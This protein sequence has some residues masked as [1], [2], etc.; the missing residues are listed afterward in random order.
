MESRTLVAV[1]QLMLMSPS[2]A[3]RGVSADLVIIYSLMREFT[4]L[5]SVHTLIINILFR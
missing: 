2:V 1:L 5:Y 3:G 4:I